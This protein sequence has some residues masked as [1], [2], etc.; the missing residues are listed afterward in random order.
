MASIEQRGENTYRIVVS[1]RKGNRFAK[2][3]KSIELS[4]N[5]TDKQKEKELKRL[6]L[7][8]EEDV[9]KGNYLDGEKITFADFTEIWLR[10]YAE[11]ELEPATLN[12]YKMR[13]EKRILPAI[14]HLKLTKIQPQHLISFYNNLTEE[15][16]RLDISY[17]PTSEFLRLLENV[18]YSEIQA[19]TGLY[20]RIFTRLKQGKGIYLQNV[21][22]LCEYFHIDKN[23]MNTFFVVKNPDEK[24]S[25][26]TIRHHHNIISGI[27][28]TAVSWNLILYNPAQR[29]KLSSIV[30]AKSP[31]AK[32]YNDEQTADLL[33]SLADEPIKYVAILYLTIDTGLRLSDGYVKHGLKNIC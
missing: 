33:M 30:K 26:K 21:E 31:E 17:L 23:D 6:A 9:K 3:T 19:Q 13:L 10:E 20:R 2:E 32:Y 27:L 1:V 11:K 18:N 25:A 15:G 28:S 4:P 24:L 14:G 22:K 12:P 16:I 8:F 5:L 29:V 7:L